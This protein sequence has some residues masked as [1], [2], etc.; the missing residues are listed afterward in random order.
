MISSA[1]I[2][3]APTSRQAHARSPGSV[4]RTDRE[5]GQLTPQE[6]KIVDELKA[7]DREVRA[8]EQAHK[9]VG[10]QYAGQISYQYQGGP[11]GKQYAVGGQ[12]P[13]D[14]APISGDPK[15]TIAKMETV[16]AAALAPAEPSSAD[17]A[18]AQE[19]KSNKAQAQAELRTERADERAGRT[20]SDN[21]NGVQDRI[22]QLQL[23]KEG[24]YGVITGAQD[25]AFKRN[26]AVFA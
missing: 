10:G 26:N 23:E 22:A 13:I 15:A 17:R 12:V 20:E 7:R 18:V 5:A 16:I 14:T 8:H 25:G 6:Q 2:Q 21:S 19:A 11:D 9:T 24:A 1:H 3:A 4:E